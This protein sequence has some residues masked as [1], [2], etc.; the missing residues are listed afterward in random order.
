[1]KTIFSS[2]ILLL[3]AKLMK[4]CPDDMISMFIFTRERQHTS[5]FFISREQNHRPYSGEVSISI[6]IKTLQIL[7]NDWNVC[8]KIVFVSWEYIDVSRERAPYFGT[9]WIS[10][11]SPPSSVSDYII[12][13][14][15]TIDDSVA[16]VVS[17]CIRITVY[18]RV[19]TNM[20]SDAL[21]SHAFQKYD[22]PSRRSRL[23]WRENVM[24]ILR[25]V[26]EV[27]LHHDRY[28]WKR[29]EDNES[30]FATYHDLLKKTNT[31][32]E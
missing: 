19:I 10:L 32:I 22:Y 8:R 29:S 14:G 18:E 16:L 31:K 24:S 21:R 3:I 26:Y 9:R 17:V 13:I 4:I 23:V 5:F 28:L 25:W 20:T 1:M 27:S 6:I 15:H 2:N 11:R 12:S 30:N 7:K